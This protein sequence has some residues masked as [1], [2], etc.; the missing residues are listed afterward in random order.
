MAGSDLVT[1]LRG[2]LCP[3][4]T[5]HEAEQVASA[6]VPQR[7]PAGE[8]ICREGEPGVGL[9]FMVR[10]TAE[11]LREGPETTQV[12]ATVSAP[13]MLGEIALLT[14][15]AISATVRAHSD[16]DC[17][18]LTR[19]Q[20]HRLTEQ[21]NAAAYKLVMAMAQL[22]AHRLTAMNDRVIALSHG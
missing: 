11:I 13:I 9:I 8:R 14:G 1:V 6:A 15:H 2:R 21:G 7:T 3:G 17:Y 4:L 5:L 19:S 10:G 18:I 12:V 22:L 16:C 20:F